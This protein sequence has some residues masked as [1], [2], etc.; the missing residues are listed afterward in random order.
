MLQYKAMTMET[1]YIVFEDP[2]VGHAPAAGKPA[3]S[4]NGAPV[5]KKTVDLLETRGLG[6]MYGA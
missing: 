2:L 4:A 3:A 1:H 6:G 5:A